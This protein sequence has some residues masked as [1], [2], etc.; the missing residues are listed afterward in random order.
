MR[1]FKRFA[2][3][4]ADSWLASHESVLLECCLSVTF[5]DCGQMVRDR[6]MVTM[7]HCW[8]VDIGLS[9]SAKIFGMDDLEEVI[10][11]SRMLKLPISSSWCEISI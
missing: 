1:V 11:R 8:E 4:F 2:L 6:P 5:V 10:S 3:I 7:R 9:E